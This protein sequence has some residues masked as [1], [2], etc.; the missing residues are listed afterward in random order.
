MDA[1]SVKKEKQ[2]SVLLSVIGSKV[3]SVLHSLLAPN[4]PTSDE[5]SFESIIDIL[6]N[7][8]DPK[9]SEIAERFHFY[10]RAQ[11]PS[12]SIPEY[13]VELKRLA[14]QGQLESALHDRFVRGIRQESL[15][16]R[17]LAE[18]DLTF[19]KAVELAKVIEAAD[20]STKEMKVEASTVAV[21]AGSKP[22]SKPSYSGP[23]QRQGAGCHQC[24]DP[25]HSGDSCKV[26]DYTC[27]HCHKKGHLA[28]VCHSR[29][30]QGQNQQ[31]APRTSYRSHG[32]TYQV[33]VEDE[34]PQDLESASLFKVGVS[35][36]RPIQ[37]EITLDDKPTVME[38]DT[39]ASV[40]LISEAQFFDLFPTA[41]LQSSRI[42]LN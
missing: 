28:R 22:R 12:E 25:S 36:I 42:Q 39:G 9:P 2:K 38:G 17:L 20:K 34:S 8:Y 21:H 40:S 13:V 14:T 19:K 37:V 24:G 11:G 26:K 16:K 31:Q 29:K 3:Y 33:E 6:Q 27:H 41:S 1:N 15:Q 30:S 4:I 32:R 23:R 18:K 7:H 5:V 35:G 10:S